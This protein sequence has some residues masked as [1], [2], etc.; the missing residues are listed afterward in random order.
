MDTTSPNPLTGTEGHSDPASRGEAAE[1]EFDAGAIADA[2]EFLQ[3]L[4][5]PFAVG[6]PTAK[7]Y[8]P[9]LVDS[10]TAQGWKL[11]DALVAELTKGQRPNNPQGALKTR[12]ENLVRRHRA[13]ATATVPGQVRQLRQSGAELP[14][15]CGDLDCD[16]LTR[17]KTTENEEGWRT[18]APCADCHP[19][20]VRKSAAAGT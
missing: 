20:K 6:R 14:P 19:G 18:T 12:I 13:A 7:R 16:E 3:E 5:A 1:A 2:E 10:T 17:M 11:D 4:P 8:A 15:H 9:L